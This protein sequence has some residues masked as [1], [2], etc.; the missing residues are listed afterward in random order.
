MRIHKSVS[1][2]VNMEKN[3]EINDIFISSFYYILFQCEKYMYINSIPI[4][5]SILEPTRSWEY[6]YINIIY[7]SEQNKMAN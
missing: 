6:T 1:H 2:L 7:F 3:I 4:I 5:F